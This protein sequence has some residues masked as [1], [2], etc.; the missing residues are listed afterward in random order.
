MKLMFT[1]SNKIKTKE[2]NKQEYIVN[3]NPD[4][5][6][7]KWFTKTF[8]QK[9]RTKAVIFD[10]GQKLYERYA[11]DF[12]N[13]GYDVK[14]LHLAEMY[15]SDFYNPFKYFEND[16]EIFDFA[17]TFLPFE[18]TR[19]Q[20]KVL[21]LETLMLY[22]IKYT[23]SSQQTFNSL[24][25][26]AL[27]DDFS[28]MLPRPVIEIK[29]SALDVLLNKVETEHPKCV[30]AKNYRALKTLTVKPNLNADLCS[31]L[32]D[33]LIKMTEQDDMDFKNIIDRNVIYFIIYDKNQ[34]SHWLL[35]IFCRQISKYINRD[36]KW[37]IVNPPEQYLHYFE[38]AV[39][40][41]Y[42]MMKDNRIL[43]S[44]LSENEIAY[45]QTNKEDAFNTTPVE[46]EEEQETTEEHTK[47]TFKKSKKYKTENK[48][49]NTFDNNIALSKQY[50]PYKIKSIFDD[51]I[52][53]QNNAKEILSVA[54]YKHLLK[55]DNPTKEFDKTNI[56]LCGPTGCGKTE[57][58]RVISKEFNLPLVVMDATTI[59]ET[60]YKGADA[61][62]MLKRLYGATNG[63]L[64]KAQKGIVYIDE[65]DKI[66]TTGNNGYRDSYQSG[67]QQSLLKMIEGGKFD[68]E[69]T[70]GERIM[71]DT[72]NVL[73]ILGGA[74][75]SITS[76]TDRVEIKNIGFTQNEKTTELKP[77]K[78]EDI[79]KFGLARELVG[80]VPTIVQLQNLSTEDIV[81]IATEPKNSIVKQ[82]KNMFLCIKNI[83]LIFT[84]DALLE[85]AT[86]AKSAQIGAR[87]LKYVFEEIIRPLFYRTTTDEIAEYSDIIINKEFV[88]GKED[89]TV[90]PPA[91]EKNEQTEK[92]DLFIDFGEM[93]YCDKQEDDLC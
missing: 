25:K 7:D 80:R 1:I 5:D 84:P 44:A 29:K 62:D 74:F 9:I 27:A 19:K 91:K 47:T 73:F 92:D 45:T 82:Y 81:K 72:E 28:S 46:S 12:N 14:I 71:F 54:I 18:N 42:P 13:K 26:L 90:Q 78:H 66:A 61:T 85:I 57:F 8:F 40:K 65:I 55:L 60:G 36:N 34:L 77:L 89:I 43:F 58:A 79:I 38:N 35:D 32:H 63:D 22:I 15:R 2:K 86:K 64:E 11:K 48:Q 69:I 6:N 17:Q 75:S 33:D 56:L 39:K 76:E 10:E 3:I 30:V 70:R 67:T 83:N 37:R 88:L 50:T 49:E 4:I 41:V 23:P 16:A 21:M 53:G 93:S 24:L 51:Y 68:I 59:T 87:G 20:E 31:I 52:V